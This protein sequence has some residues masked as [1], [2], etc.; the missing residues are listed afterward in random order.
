MASTVAIARSSHLQLM[1][2][3]FDRDYE[4]ACEEWGLDAL[5][6][7]LWLL[8]QWLDYD[9]SGH[10]TMLYTSKNTWSNDFLSDFTSDKPR[11]MMLL[12]EC[13]RFP[14]LDRSIEHLNCTPLWRIGLMGCFQLILGG[15]SKSASFR[16]CS[17]N[18]DF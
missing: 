12:W 15:L 2:H 6:P 16:E 17:F 4:A 5:Q 9:N 3:P 18:Y 8:F 10:R 14:K 1:A 7:S 11:V 13:T